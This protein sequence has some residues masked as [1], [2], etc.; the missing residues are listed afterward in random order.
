MAET[1]ECKGCAN[2]VSADTTNLMGPWVFCSGCF[3]DLLDRRAAPKAPPEELEAEPEVHSV[4][5]PEAGSDG[6]GISFSVSAP[7]ALGPSCFICEKSIGDGH[8]ENVAAHI[9]CEPCFDNLL[10]G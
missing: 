4:P 3:Q 2:T 9:V 8:Y 1:V 5:I 6:A 7:V 10:P